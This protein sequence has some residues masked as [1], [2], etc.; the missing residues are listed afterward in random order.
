MTKQFLGYE[1]FGYQKFFMDDPALVAKLLQANHDRM[2]MLMF[3]KDFREYFA[4]VG[5]PKK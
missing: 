1:G 4:K 5:G 3:A 2:E